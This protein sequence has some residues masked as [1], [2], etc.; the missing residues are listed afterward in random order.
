MS[1]ADLPFHA[2]ITMLFAGPDDYC[3]GKTAV[4][5]TH[6]NATTGFGD[7]AQHR[8]EVVRRLSRL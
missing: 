1:A 5:Y 2:S 6:E 8:H 3:A 4:V 7:H